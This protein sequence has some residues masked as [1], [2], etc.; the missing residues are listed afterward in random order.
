MPQLNPAAHD[1]E[2]TS[3]RRTWRSWFTNERIAFLSIVMVLV[4]FGF[5]QGNKASHR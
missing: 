3:G 4:V 5:S 1:V 2:E